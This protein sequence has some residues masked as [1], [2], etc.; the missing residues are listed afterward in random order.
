MRRLL[1]LVASGSLLAATAATA[2]SSPEVVEIQTNVGTIAIRLNYAKAPITTDNFMQYVD[3]GFY[4]GTLLHR[5]V[6]DFVVQ[7]GGYSK[8]DGALKQTQPP[9][10][11]ESYNGLSNLTGTIAM[12]RTSDPNSATAQ[13]FINLVDNTFL[14]YASAASPGYAVFGKVVKGMPVA[15][16]I[17]A[18]ANYNSVAFTPTAQLVWIETVYKNATWD[19]TIARTRVL[20][21]GSGTVVSNPAGIDCGSTCSISQAKGAA[22]KLTATP[23][24]GY[25]FTGWRG[26]C[27]GARKVLNID[28]NKGNHN[29]TA[30][31]T[32]L[33]A[34]LQ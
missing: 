1:T 10:I 24:A 26:D 33:G 34:A 25:A 22:L 19:T 15:S 8:T 14:D 6:K 27:S 9:I 16:E 28:T 5:T 11:N 29:C 13:F 32:A 4:K 2:A 31:F 21:S 3:S 7:G 23:A 20:K 18:L 30:V 17:E 12:A